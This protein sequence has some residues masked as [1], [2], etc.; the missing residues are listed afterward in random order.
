MA[1]D[2]W[3]TQLKIVIFHR[4][5]DK[6][7]WVNGSIFHKACAHINHI[8]WG[9]VP[10]NLWGP[11]M[12]PVAPS[13][14]KN[15]LDPSRTPMWK[16]PAGLGMAWLRKNGLGCCLDMA[17]TSIYQ[18]GINRTTIYNYI[19]TRIYLCMCIYI[20]TVTCR[21][22][23]TQR[24]CR[25]E[26]LGCH[27]AAWPRRLLLLAELGRAQFDFCVSMGDRHVSMFPST[28]LLIL[29]SMNFQRCFLVI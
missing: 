25:L 21:L 11:P 18:H 14:P 26:F 2:S 23:S 19:Y 10:C 1:I 24:T 8:F 15:V 29:W 4:K 28:L 12:G 27:F 5:Y 13:D 20:Y 7:H 16:V 9:T 3:L 6:Y 17:N 22:L